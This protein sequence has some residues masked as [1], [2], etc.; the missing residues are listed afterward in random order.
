MNK[1]CRYSSPLFF[2][3]SQRSTHARAQRGGFWRFLLGVVVL[4]GIGGVGVL[5]IYAL[6]LDDVVRSKFEGKRW[7]L[8]ARVYARPLELYQGRTLA[9]EALVAE[10]ERLKYL[11]V[12]EVD[13]PGTY[14]RDGNKVRF[15]THGFRFWDGAE[16]SA[17]LEVTFAEGEV[18]AVATLDQGPAITL[19]RLDPAL[20]ASVYPTH[21]EDRVLLRRAQL[22]DLL[23]KT[24]LAVEDRKFYRHFGVDPKGIVRAAFKNL[25]AGRTVEGAST[26]TQQLVKNFYLNQERTLERKLN[27]ALMA[28][29]LELRY[30]KDDILTA[31]A[32]EVYM[33]Q[34]GS[35]GIH[36]FG[37][38]SRFYFDRALSELD[39]A[40][41]A[42]LVAVL[43]GPS[44]YNPRRHPEKTLERRNLVIDIMAHHQIISLAEAEQAK[45]APLGLREGGA[46]PSGDYPAFVQ[47]VRRQLQRDYREEDLRSEGLKIFTTLDP[48][49][50]TA[51]EQAIRDRLPKLEKQRGY[52][53][54]TFESAA[55][56]T[57]VAQGEVLALV[58]SRNAAFEGFNRA[59]D[60]VRSIGSAVKPVIYL[61][62]L[63]RPEQF[64]LA[65][66]I[67]DQPVSLRIG[68]NVWEPKNYDHRVHGNVPL[69]RALA[70][71]Y[72]LAAVN[73]GL[74]LGVDEVAQTLRRLGAMRQINA[75]PAMLLG[76]VSLAPIELAQVYQTIAAG[77]FRTPLRAIREVLDSSGRPLTRYPLAVEPVVRGDAAFMTQW[78]MRQVVEQGTAV[79]L[80]QRLPQGLSVAGKTGTTNDLRDSW[81]AGF[82]GDKVAVVWV[83]R[84]NNKSTGLT[85]SSGALRV[86]GDLMANIDNQPLSDIPPDGVILAQGCG[87]LTM[88]VNAEFAE[89]AACREPSGQPGGEAVAEADSGTDTD[90]EESGPSREQSRPASDREDRGSRNL[91]L[92][93]FYGD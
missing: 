61:T 6:Q 9:P 40:D 18:S 32:N 44:E 89:M 49:I 33:G 57:S 69:Y 24:L 3:R 53:S 42:L 2:R 34:D 38:A 81:F 29:L 58:G 21:N 83:G 85:G 13:R 52:S 1:L 91:F 59:L 12:T 74:E 72:N 48:L 79:W 11:P 17:L 39:V 80:K 87:G 4:L 8:P 77:G 66:S 43:K 68:A 75:V 5:G 62:A 86:W 45:A 30:A 73:L 37:L 64:S 90:P 55:V 84:D 36:G 10:L 70:K 31:Y 15:Y 20:I 19:V 28:M 51:A 47:L 16:R 25:M 27:E 65:T 78:A 71:S 35:R 88:P 60:A 63:E 22:P 26:L 56:V 67:P 46:R 23:V 50:Q 82:S 54:G 14:H 92:S 41:T 76:S 93:D 7:A